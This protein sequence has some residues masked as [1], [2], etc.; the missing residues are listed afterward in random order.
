M[1]GDKVEKM[2]K[3]DRKA[4]PKIAEENVT[5]ENDIENDC[6][7]LVCHNPEFDKNVTIRRF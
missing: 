3:E 1:N 7:K 5:S 2:A 4:L 6:I